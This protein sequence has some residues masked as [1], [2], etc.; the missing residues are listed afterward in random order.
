MKNKETE[1]RKDKPKCQRKEEKE[2]G[3]VLFF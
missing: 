2:G 3:N 1:K